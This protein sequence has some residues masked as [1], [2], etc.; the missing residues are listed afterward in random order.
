MNQF[1]NELED[2]KFDSS[3]NENEPEPSSP[4]KEG[5]SVP[6]NGAADDTVNNEEEFGMGLEGEEEAAD[7]AGDI[8]TDANGKS[9]FD[10]KRPGKDEVS[11][12]PE[13]NQVMIR[14]IPPDIGRMKLETVSSGFVHTRI[15]ANNVIRVGYQRHARLRLSRTGRSYA[16]A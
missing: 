16:K 3:F 2:G 9:T 14:T 5:S 8:K 7:N 13:G 12:M 1:V 6:E 10:A 4:V 15:T 11:V